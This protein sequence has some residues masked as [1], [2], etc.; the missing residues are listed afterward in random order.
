MTSRMCFHVLDFVRLEA[1]AF[2]VPLTDFLAALLVFLAVRF[3]AFVVLEAAFLPVSAGLGGNQTALVAL[4]FATSEAPRAAQRCL[5]VT[6]L[7]PLLMSI[8]RAPS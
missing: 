3:D 6:L 7:N 8:T 4:V 5:S 1:A 2:L